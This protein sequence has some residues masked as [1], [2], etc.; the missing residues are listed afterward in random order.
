M[1]TYRTQNSSFTNWSSCI[2]VCSKSPDSHVRSYPTAHARYRNNFLRI[3]RMY[4]LHH[5][6]YALHGEL[7]YSPIIII[8]YSHNI[9]GNRTPQ[10]HALY[11]WKNFIA[12]SK[13]KTIDI[14]AHSFGGVV[15]IDWV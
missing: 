4:H 12:H 6:I 1:E 9:Q 8:S 10:E 5:D 13:A 11:V 7:M 15:T 14:V 3:F 2:H